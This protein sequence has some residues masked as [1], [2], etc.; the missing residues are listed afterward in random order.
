MPSHIAFS[1]FLAAAKIAYPLKYK[2]IA[3]DIESKLNDQVR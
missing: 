2:E 3:E 1:A